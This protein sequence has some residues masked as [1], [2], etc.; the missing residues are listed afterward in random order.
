[1]SDEWEGYQLENAIDSVGPGWATIIKDLWALKPDSVKVTT[2]KE[3]L[4]G[5]RV[6]FQ[7]ADE[8]D[9]NF[10]DEA[11]ED[12]EVEAE[13]TCEFC[14]KIGSIREDSYAKYHWYKCVCE[15]HKDWH[16]M[17]LRTYS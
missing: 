13:H 7:A 9:Y 8:Y 2:V 16:D 15:E 4:G 6:Y 12:A 17:N 5:L 14:G 11:V 1:M 3:K 10:F